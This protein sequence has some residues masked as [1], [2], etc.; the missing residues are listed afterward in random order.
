MILYLNKSFKDEVTAK[1]VFG[2]SLAGLY[3]A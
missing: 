2:C 1:E 3:L